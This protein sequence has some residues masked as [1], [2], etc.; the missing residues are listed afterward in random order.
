ME[1]WSN[2]AGAT[3]HRLTLESMESFLDK[4]GKEASKWRVDKEKE[5]HR[6]LN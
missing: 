6:I 1:Q 3:C 4:E 2:G 5:E